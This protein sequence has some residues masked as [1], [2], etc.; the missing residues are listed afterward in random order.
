MTSDQAFDNFIKNFN[1]NNGKIQ[2]VE[3]DDYYAAVS[4]TMENDDHFIYLVKSVWQL[5]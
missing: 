1:E 2:K 5:E 3:W 4:A